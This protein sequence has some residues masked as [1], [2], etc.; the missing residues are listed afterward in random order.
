MSKIVLCPE[1]HHTPEAAAVRT[2]IQLAML[3][4]RLNCALSGSDVW[5]RIPCKGVCPTPEEL[6]AWA[7]AEALRRLAATAE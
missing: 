2:R 4:G 7:A 5:Q 6:I 3:C 1:A